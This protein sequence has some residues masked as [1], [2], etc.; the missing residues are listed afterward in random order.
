[1]TKNIKQYVPI[2]VS[3]TS[4][5]MIPYRKAALNT[6]DKLKVAVKGMEV[7]GARTEE[8]IKTCLDEV[9]KS[10]FFI[11]ILG[12]RYGSLDDETGKSIV[13]LEYEKAKEESLEILIYLMDKEKANIHP[14]LVD[15]YEKAKKLEDFKEL[16][17]K[18]HTY[19][20]FQSP[21]DLAIKIERD[22]LRQF[23][24]KGLVIE[25]RRLKPTI[26]SEKTKELLR[27]FDLMPKRL[28]GSE[29]E[30][31]IKFEGSPR[32]V[33]KRLCE[34]I[35]LGFGQSISRSIAVIHPQMEILD[36]IVRLYAEY[37]G[38]D[39]LYDAP[40][41]K[42]FK[43]IAR[44]VFGEEREDTWYQRSL[45]PGFISTFLRASPTA[46][47]ETSGPSFE[48]DISYTPVKALVL[49]KTVDKP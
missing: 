41:G 27:K 23:S 11:C 21:K 14:K 24:E 38:C 15:R 7:F 40:M 22:L 47:L 10:Q 46:Y 20:S 2:F 30:L 28:T 16:L 34:A 37:D 39:F 43:I 29:V 17:V 9:S 19:D 3:S 18:K 32:S 13:H 12:M 25:K 35:N 1:M 44:L 45:S 6:L 36:F 33:S 49:V 42:E 31:I 4:K 48:H 26:E 8:P 5:D